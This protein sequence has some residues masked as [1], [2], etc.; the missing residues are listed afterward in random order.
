MRKCI[1]DNNIV[2]NVIEIEEGAEWSPPEGMILGPEGGEIGWS[3]DGE[4][5]INPIQYTP[6]PPKYTQPIPGKGPTFI[7]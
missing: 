7:S 5:Y 6:N 3:W 1:I 2:V 4:K